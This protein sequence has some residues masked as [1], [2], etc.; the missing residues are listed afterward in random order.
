MLRLT[1]FRLPPHPLVLACYAA[2]ISAALTLSPVTDAQA[3]SAQVNAVAYKPMPSGLSVYVRPRDDS[4]ENLALKRRIESLLA[5]RGYKIAANRKDG[6]TL[7]FETR[8]L[9]GAYA[10]GGRRHW[11]ELS[12]Q[13]GNGDETASAKVNLYDS[14]SGGL[15]NS[16]EN[17]G[18]SVTSK[19]KVRL[20]MTLDQASVRERFWSGW[21]VG[22]L[23][24]EQW[25]RQAESMLPAL[26]DSLGQTVK[27]KA[28][29]T[30]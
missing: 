30:P 11:L 6:L 10:D 27:Q 18:T 17:E 14:Q 19:A 2:L 15:F 26:I 23:G 16:G 28:V 8:E 7:T 25:S 5:E 29:D 4:A 1:I 21:A 9:S 24:S 12:G 20:D 13:A 22:D 3:E